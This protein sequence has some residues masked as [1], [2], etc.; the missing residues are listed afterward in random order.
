MS[1]PR[2]L[3]NTTIGVLVPYSTVLVY[4]YWHRTVPSVLCPVQ[5]MPWSWSRQFRSDQIVSQKSASLSIVVGLDLL[6]WPSYDRRGR[7]LSLPLAQSSHQ[8]PP[9]LSPAPRLARP[10]QEDMENYRTHHIARG[11][12]EGTRL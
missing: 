4:W 11:D 10:G 12:P 5:Y 1:R 3:E 7:Y 8:Y 2:N 6:A 9:L